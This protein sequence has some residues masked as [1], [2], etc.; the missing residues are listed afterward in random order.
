[1]DDQSNKPYSIFTV[2]TL[3]F[4]LDA[5]TMLNWM[6]VTAAFQY[7]DMSISG[8]YFVCT[9]VL[10]D[11]ITNDCACPTTTIIYTSH[12]GYERIY[13]LTDCHRLHFDY[14]DE[15]INT[16]ALNRFDWGPELRNQW[17]SSYTHSYIHTHTPCFVVFF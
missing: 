16:D 15:R 5:L 13:T 10:N 14:N 2:I 4:I 8:L 9:C 7:I 17:R 12:R 11:L 6:N 1:M 3:I